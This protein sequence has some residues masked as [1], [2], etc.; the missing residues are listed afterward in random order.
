M[1]VAATYMASISVAEE[2]KWCWFI[3]SLCGLAG[4]ILSLVRTYKP[5]AEAR[6]EGVSEVRLHRSSLC[7]TPMTARFHAAR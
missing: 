3:L 6:S 4:Y 1:W 7:H 2:V 5:A